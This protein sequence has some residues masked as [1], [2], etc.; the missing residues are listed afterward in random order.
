VTGSVSSKSAPSSPPE[1]PRFEIRPIKPTG[2]SHSDSIH[3]EIALGSE[4]QATQAASFQTVA[5]HQA[6]EK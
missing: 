4:H 6:I 1:L 3:S 5:R 2:E